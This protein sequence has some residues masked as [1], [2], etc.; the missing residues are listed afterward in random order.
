MNAYELFYPNKSKSACL[1]GSIVTWAHLVIRTGTSRIVAKI[2][3]ANLT[4]RD[5]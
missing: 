1:A 2:V 3:N 4:N 5:V